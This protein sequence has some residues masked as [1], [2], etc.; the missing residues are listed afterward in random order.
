MRY[1]IRKSNGVLHVFDTVEYCAVAMQPANRR[2]EAFA[3]ASD[4]NDRP[5]PRLASLLG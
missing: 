3:L 2:A 5:N 4:L 1:E